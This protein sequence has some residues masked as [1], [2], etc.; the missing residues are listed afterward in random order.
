M[1]VELEKKMVDQKEKDEQERKMK[2]QLELQEQRHNSKLKELKDTLLKVTAKSDRNEADVS[3]LST[4]TVLERRITMENFS[5]KK[6]TGILWRSPS[7]YT[8]L[9]GYKFC[10]EV[11]PDGFKLGKGKALLI[12]VRTMSGEYDDTLK[13]PGKFKMTLQLTNQHEGENICVSTTSI[14]KKTER[15]YFEFYGFKRK[16]LG[17]LDHEEV[18]DFLKNDSLYFVVTEVS[19]L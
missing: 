13:W 4:M 6:A 5:A 14:M 19:A 8:H 7:M 17:M 9:C 1:I 15:E 16:P 10:I 12:G 18:K 11:H 2:E 3:L